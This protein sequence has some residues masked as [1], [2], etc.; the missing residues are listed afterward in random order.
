M[1][2]QPAIACYLNPTGAIVL[3]QDTEDD[4]F[5]WF[6][7]EHAAAVAAAILEA[8]GLDAAALKVDRS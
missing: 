8:A 4:H 2:G 1:P 7:P 6:H 3:R 5:V